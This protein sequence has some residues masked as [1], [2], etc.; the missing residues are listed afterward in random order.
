MS[1]HIHSVPFF[2]ELSLYRHRYLNPSA[3]KSV[4]TNKV[5]KNEFVVFQLELIIFRMFFY[6][7]AR[8]MGFVN[9]FFRS[10]IKIS[11]SM[12]V[13]LV[14]FRNIGIKLL[15]N[16][17]VSFNGFIESGVPFPVSATTLGAT[18]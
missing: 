10:I 11:V 6:F 5:R 12:A 15:A 3:A 2:I 16:D 1:F 8:L 14:Y 7:T 9:T 17:S 18:V 4:I 13:G